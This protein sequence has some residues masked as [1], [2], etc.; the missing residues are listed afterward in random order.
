[1]DLMRRTF[2]WA[3]TNPWFASTLPRRRFVKRAVRRFMPG[4]TREDAL[5]EA[6]SLA[7]RGVPSIL[8]MLG[9]NVASEDE[10]RAVV[11]EYRAVLT[12]AAERGLDVEVSVKPT[13][14]GLDL[15]PAIAARNIAD[16]AMATGGRGTLWIDMEG[17]A[18][19]DATLDL[20][21]GLTAEHANVGVCL[22]SYLRRTD[23]D[24]EAL[25]PL[26]PRIRL[27]KGAYA[28]P[29]EIAFPAKRDVDA[30]YLS[31]GRRLLD[32]FADGGEGFVGFGT[33]DPALI[34][35]LAADVKGVAR[36]AERF[37]IEM[38]YG[39]G[40]RE[41]D[42]LVEAGVPLR[43]L[44]SYGEAWF[45]WYMRRLAERPANVWFVVRS[46]IR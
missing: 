41:Q 37:E 28:E 16:L 13:H 30:R 34:R 43:I 31:L 35:A 4:E 25:L 7:T 18:Y 12:E 9:E 24:L 33:H 46:L 22:Q 14:L 38:L 5:R 39:I 8:T 32:H 40:R 23:A 29:P 26:S 17:S 21:R 36:A 44:I 45:P 27:V 15:S 2:L 10:T 19:T 20:Y 42:R 6:A 1:M 3:S 11:D